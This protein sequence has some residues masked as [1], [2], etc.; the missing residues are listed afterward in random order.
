MGKEFFALQHLVCQA[1]VQ[2]MWDVCR[3]MFIQFMVD[4]SNE[5]NR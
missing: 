4:L 1:Y 2:G 5:E 3:E